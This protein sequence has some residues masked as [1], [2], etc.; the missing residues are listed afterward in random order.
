MRAKQL[1]SIKTNKAGMS[2]FNERPGKNDAHATI[3]D[4]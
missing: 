1:I 2:E 3:K 4:A